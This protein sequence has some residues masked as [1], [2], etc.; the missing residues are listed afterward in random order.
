MEK[1]SLL[2]ALLS[3][4]ENE[5]LENMVKNPHFS[6]PSFQIF[7]GRHIIPNFSPKAMEY[8]HDK[9]NVKASDVFVVSYPKTGLIILLFHFFITSLSCRLKLF[10]LKLKYFT[11]KTKTRYLLFNACIY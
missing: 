2:T 1:F 11:H 3:N 9:W 4:E 6:L 5:L 8:V 10:S 7:K